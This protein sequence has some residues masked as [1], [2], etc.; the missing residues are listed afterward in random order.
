MQSI[1]NDKGTEIDVWSEGEQRALFS[2]SPV[3]LPVKTSAAE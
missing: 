1:F 3:A 2:S